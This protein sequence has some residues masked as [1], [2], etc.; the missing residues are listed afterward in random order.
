M[1]HFMGH[2]LSQAERHKVT[3]AI[4]AA[5]AHTM[6]EIVVVA[7]RESDDYIHVPI[8]I[9]T[10]CALAVP[11]LIWLWQQAN[12]WDAGF[13]LGWL[14]LIQLGVF[15][16]VALAL[17][18]PRIR[19]AVT[20]MRLKHKYAHRNAAAQFLATN[21]AATKQRTGVLIFVSLMERYVEVIGDEA[22]AAK[23]SAGDWQKIIDEMLP[24][25]KDKRSCDALVL[26]VQ[27]A[28]VL[29]AKHF[30]A[31]AHVKNELPNGFI[32]LD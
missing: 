4:T 23:L 28:G 6:G 30:P 14:F 24:L 7:A 11:V 25:L 12:P 21:I 9:A 10:G 19:R 31:K 26:G 3:A 27:H 13:S 17:S 5:E 1:T 8:H 18:L 29:L 32:V 2:D 22:I 16:V 20:P 15:I